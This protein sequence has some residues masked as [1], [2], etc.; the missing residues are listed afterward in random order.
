[1]RGGKVNMILF[2]CFDFFRSWGETFRRGGSGTVLEIP[3]EVRLFT[4]V[5]YMMIKQFKGRK[6]GVLV[7]LQTVSSR[8]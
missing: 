2:V 5:Y 6:R 4:Y 7:V 1:M 8:E 3:S